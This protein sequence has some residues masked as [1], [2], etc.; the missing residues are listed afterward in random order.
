MPFYESVKF[1]SG[2][3]VYQS[4]PKLTNEGL[5]IISSEESGLITRI[6]VSVSQIYRIERY[7]SRNER[8]HCSVPSKK[9]SNTII[10][11]YGLEKS[12]SIYKGDTN[13][14]YDILREKYPEFNWE[15]YHNADGKGYKRLAYAV[16]YGNAP[17]KIINPAKTQA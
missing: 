10:T 17:C 16:T 11:N 7:L 15:I 8:F 4:E 5:Q 9:E 13:V 2:G 6:R 1:R 12:G 14:I 3:R